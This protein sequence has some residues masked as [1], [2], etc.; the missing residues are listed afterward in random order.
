M[1]MSGDRAPS[2]ARMPAETSPSLPPGAWWRAC[3][4]THWWTERHEPKGWRCM[5]CH[6]PD[7]LPR[8]AVRH[9]G[10][11]DLVPLPRQEVEP[12]FQLAGI[13]LDEGM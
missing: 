4:G 6:P 5:M 11:A 3:Q 9:E 2:L 13:D 12:L 8:E 7:H 1:G 10:E